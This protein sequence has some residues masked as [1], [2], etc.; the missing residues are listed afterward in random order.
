M[1]FA[2]SP[3]PRICIDG[4]TVQL[5]APDLDGDGI[6]GGTER[7]SA[8]PKKPYDFL[9]TKSELGEVTENMNKDEIEAGIDMSTMD[10]MSRLHPVQIPAIAVW[11]YLVKSNFLMADALHVSRQIKRLEVSREGQGRTE[12]VEVVGRKTETEAKKGLGS[13]MRK[14]FGGKDE[15]Q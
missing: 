12:W 11:D 15:T 7:I 13:M 14:T 9:K 1:R 2:I 6:T 3:K 10:K 8:Q 4:T 5:Q